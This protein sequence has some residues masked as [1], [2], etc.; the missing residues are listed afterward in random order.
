[1][2]AAVST[3]KPSSSSK[4]AMFRRMGAWSSITRI[5]FMRLIGLL[6]DNFLDREQATQ[7]RRKSH[8]TK[9]GRR[10]C[11]SDGINTDVTAEQIHVLRKS[12]DTLEGQTHVAALV[13]YRRLFELDPIKHQRSHVGLS[14]ER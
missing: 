10:L 8:P 1:P 12:F 5:F 7:S 6:V 9:V 4:R 11:F 13:F 3:S 14:F 2:L